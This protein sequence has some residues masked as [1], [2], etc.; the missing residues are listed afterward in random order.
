MKEAKRILITGGAGFIGSHLT[1]KLLQENRNVC[2]IDNFLTGSEENLKPHKNLVVERGSVIDPQW[3]NEVFDRFRPEVVIHAAAAYKDPEAW[4]LDALTNV[5]GTIHVVKAAQRLDVGRFIYFQTALSYGLKPLEQPITFKHPLFSG[6]Y[7]G[8]SSYAIS[9]TSGELYIQLSGLDFISFRLANV[10][11]PRN[12]SGPV[13]IF[14]QRLSQGKT[15][16]VMNTRRDFIFVGDL[17]KVV[18]KAIDGMGNTGYYHVSTGSDYAIKEVFDTVVKVM[19]IRLE[20]EVDVR[21][22]DESDAYSMLLDPSKTWKD[23]DWKASAPLE[24]A[25]AAA[26][27]WYSQREIKE[28]FT[29]LNLP[30][31]GE[32]RL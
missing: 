12:L 31:K 22:R 32:H 1:E 20:K 3:V 8:G 26:V 17:V 18:M 19:G 21:E 27:A 29:H 28:T 23:F 16:F 2:V 4:D 24:E 15:C 9:K 25:I 13:A 7:A 30:G 10:I 5:V 14:Y 6:G 11:G